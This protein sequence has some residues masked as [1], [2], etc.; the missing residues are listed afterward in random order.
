[1]VAIQALVPVDPIFGPL[2]D[3]GEFQ[4]SRPHEFN[5]RLG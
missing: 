3:A 2:E 4:A 1:M 5:I